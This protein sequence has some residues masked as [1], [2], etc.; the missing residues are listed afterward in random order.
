MVQKV[1]IG[2]KDLLNM[3]K[4]ILNGVDFWEEKEKYVRKK[5]IPIPQRV[6][7]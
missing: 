5:G 4:C 3:E 7:D 6:I 1:S 2:A